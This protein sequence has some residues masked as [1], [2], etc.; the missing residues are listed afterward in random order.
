MKL[1]I[2]AMLATLV[3]LVGACAP[4]APAEDDAS[5]NVMEAT[6]EEIHQAYRDGTLTARQLTQMYLDRIEAYDKNG[7]MINSV[8]TINPKALEEAG[9]VDAEFKRTGN[10]MGPLHGIVILLKDQIDVGGMPTTL[11]SLVMKDYVPTLDAGGVAKVKQAGAIILAKMTLGEG[12]GGDTYG[13]LF[14]ATRNPYDVERTVGGSSGG[15]AAGISANFGTVAIGQEGFASIRRPST[16]NSIVGMRPTPGLVTRSGVWGGYPALTGQIG[17]MART[18][19]DLAKLLDVMVGYDPEDPTT[20]LGV[21]KHPDTYT[22]FLDRDG[23]KGAR[24]GILRESMVNLANTTPSEPE[25]QD[26]KDVTAVFDKAVADLQMAG[27]TVVDPITIPNL[28]AA[29]AKR[30]GV[31]GA[32]NSAEVY[33]ARNP[34]SPFKTQ[35]DMQAHPDFSKM[36][37]QRRDAVW[38]ADGRIPPVTGT[39]QSRALDY[40]VARDQLAIDIAKVMADH[41]LDAIV[42]KSVDHTPT[43]IKDGIDPPFINQKGVPHLNTYLIYAASLAVPAGFTSAG[44]PA[45]I[46]FFGPAYSEPTL[47]RLAYAYEQAT[48]HRVPPRTTPPLV[49]GKS[50]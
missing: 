48:H 15:P 29:L 33:F 4:V 37:G 43:L 47:I 46:T 49:N 11:G 8:I 34:N 9:R 14:G 12:G 23:L 35:Q 19:P 39:P 20:A 6:I 27:A 2:L 1:R 26:F 24:I 17:P 16:W 44:L 38:A 22:R 7:P 10:L 30:A 21:G 40:I 13:S 45:G 31:P 41:R 18:V 50:D 3:G 42:H 32:G 25:S 5:F 28:Q 36:I